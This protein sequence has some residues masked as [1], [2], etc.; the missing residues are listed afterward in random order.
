MDRKYPFWGNFLQKIEIVNLSWSLVPRPSRICRIQWYCSRFWA[1]SFVQNKYLA[2]WCYLMNLP[3]VYSKRL[4]ASGSCSYTN[5]E[6]A[7]KLI[8]FRRSKVDALCTDLFLQMTKKTIKSNL[9]ENLSASVFLWPKWNFGKFLSLKAYLRYK[10]VFSQNVPSEAQ[11][12]PFWFHR[13]LMFRS[14]DI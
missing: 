5:K 4:E 6:C 8:K 10:T 3:S 14:Q 12:K 7:L 1:A 2:F 11:A 13:K 9:Q